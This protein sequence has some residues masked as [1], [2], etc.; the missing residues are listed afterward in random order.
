MSFAAYLRDHIVELLLFVIALL[1]ICGIV[2]LCGVTVDVVVLVAIVA[3]LF[4]CTALVVGYA[5]RRAFVAQCRS[6]AEQIEHARQFYAFVDEPDLAEQRVCY[7]ALCALVRVGVDDAETEQQRTEAYRE[8]IESWIHEVKAPIAAAQLA[9]SSMTGSAANN[10]R[11]ELERV[12]QNVEQALWYARSTAV[13]ADYT[14][15]EVPLF[16]I[17]SAVCKKN[18]RL[19]IEQGVTPRFSGLEGVNVFTDEKWATFIVTQAVVNAAKYQ[20]SELRFS[21][22][23]ADDAVLG[24]QVVL[25][26]AD[27]GIGIPASD[28]PRVFDRG[29]TGINGRKTGS[30]T[31]MGLY[32]AAIMCDKMGLGL[33]IASEE[34]TGTRVLIAFP[35]DRERLDFS[36]TQRA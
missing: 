24:K 3:V 31:G 11:G 27:N 18:A 20:A 13:E 1:F 16:S 23:P 6:M 4:G 26:I 15:H 21:C 14:I 33:K 8:Y 2:Y 5:R 30:S 32:L 29:F 19:L 35:L 28:V 25:E 10:V 7:E 22:L 9:A 34:G 12:E 36:R 17:V